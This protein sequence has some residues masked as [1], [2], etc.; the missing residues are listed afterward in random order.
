MADF[1]HLTA[2]AKTREEAEALLRGLRDDASSARLA[3]QVSPRTK[4][5]WLSVCRRQ[6]GAVTAYLEALRD[7]YI[8][9]CDD[10]EVRR[11]T[12]DLPTLQS[13]RGSYRLVFTSTSPYPGFTNFTSSCYINAVLQC[14]LHCHKAR[15]HFAQ[16]QLRDGEDENSVRAALTQLTHWYVH[17]AKIEGVSSPVKFDVIAPHAL[18]QSVCEA[19]PHLFSLEDQKDAAELLAFLLEETGL[20]AEC[21]RVSRPGIDVEHPVREGEVVC[22]AALHECAAFDDFVRADTIDMQA[23]LRYA[24]RIPNRQLQAVPQIFAVKVPQY[25]STGEG[26]DYYAE[27]LQEDGVEK[28]LAEWGG[29][30][31]DFREC[32]TADCEGRDQAIYRLRSY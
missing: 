32:C 9:W 2:A 7:V 10:K 12:K 11:P 8:D 5:A 16:M 13:V 20:A 26:D 4:K 6:R 18:A 25:Y 22:L 19:R 28:R 23:L 1:A 15:E 31:F 24:L 27:W 3:S 30:R 14:L 21:F 17:G 29:D